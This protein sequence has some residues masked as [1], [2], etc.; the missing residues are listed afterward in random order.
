MTT[1]A[2]LHGAW[3]DAW[4]WD[5]VTP[6]LKQAG[7][8][9]IVPRLP[10]DDGSADFD[11][12][13]DV[14]CTSLR[15]CSDDVVVVA[16]SLAGATGALI[17][18][19]RP[20]RHLVYLCA[21]IPD[22]GVA[23]AAQMGIMASEFGEGWLAALTEPDDQLR[24]QWAD[25]DFVRRVFYGDCDEATQAAAIE[26]LRPQSAYPFAVPCPL[27]AHPSVS[28]TYVV[29]S[30]DRVVSP[31]WSR[32]KAR[33]IGANLVELPGSH[34]PFLSRPQVVAGVLLAAAST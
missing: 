2:L 18:S 10:S 7:H 25:F 33:D 1:F 29:C 34:S 6:L 15:E 12:Y 14:A 32:G 23:L 8:D 20:I 17:P 13:A 21:S 24:T 16:H 26:H 4:C 19:R 11:T 22:G 27:T 9:V 28:C 31:E 3:H 30:E 5:R